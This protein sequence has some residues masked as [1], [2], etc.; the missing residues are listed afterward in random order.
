MT[1][2]TRRSYL[3]GML[4]G[5]AGLAA[6]EAGCGAST[7]TPGSPA[8]TGATGGSTYVNVKDFGAKG[9]GLTDDT[10]AIQSALN[11]AVFAGKASVFIPPGTYSVGQLSIPSYTALIG[12]PAYDYEVGGGSLLKLN[13]PSAQCLLDITNTRGVTIQGLSLYGN[14]D[15]ASNNAHGVMRNDSVEGGTSGFENATRIDDCKIYKF[16]GDGLHMANS[17][18]WSVRHCSIADNGGDG[19]YFSGWDCW[20]LDNW[21]SNN[22]N[23]GF[24]NRGNY[25]SAATITGNRIE[26]N[27]QQ[28]IL[29]QNSAGM[30]LITGNYF[31]Y[32]YYSGVKI[33]SPAAGD[34]CEHVTITGNFFY[35]NGGKAT[36]NT[37]D[38]SHIWLSGACGVTCV[39]NACR[40]GDQSG[41][42]TGA[43]NPSYGIVHQNCQYCVI[44]NNTLFQVATYALLS[45]TGGTGN[46]VNNN[47]G[48]LHP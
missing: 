3:R 47:P 12:I 38:N 23:C 10:V 35:R 27:K 19:I 11:A 17:W 40:A 21:L 4:T 37:L 20:V 5:V 31:D 36:K 43:I 15:N 30:I 39:G 25:D 42:G 18:C 26:W 2:T 33:V 44:S 28:G 29:I 41:Q 22:G 32:S 14:N 7:G 46:A 45:A 9:D 48:T 6:F 16:G 24:A 8:Q 13:N 1:G 34:P